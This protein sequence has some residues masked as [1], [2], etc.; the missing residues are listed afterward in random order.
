LRELCCNTDYKTNQFKK[1]EINL[2][3]G[4]TSGV[5]QQILLQGVEDEVCLCLFYV[6]Q[7][8]DTVANTSKHIALSS[9][10]I[11][12]N[13]NLNITNNNEYMDF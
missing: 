7:L 9:F 5:K 10:Y 12:N 11:D 6:K 3:N 13:S 4:V 8:N 1:F 2:P